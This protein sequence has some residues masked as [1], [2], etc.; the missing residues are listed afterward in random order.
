LQTVSKRA[1]IAGVDAVE[2]LPFP[3]SSE[4]K[5]AAFDRAFGDMYN[6]IAYNTIAN[7]TNTI[8]R[9]LW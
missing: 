8:P 1:K 9:Q 4:R 2:A 7:K 5:R 3:S 6:T